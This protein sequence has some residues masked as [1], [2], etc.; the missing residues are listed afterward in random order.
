MLRLICHCKGD[1]EKRG[2]LELVQAVRAVH[3][4]TMREE[5]RLDEYHGFSQANIE[6]CAALGIKIGRYEAAANIVLKEQGP[7]VEKLK[8]EAAESQK[9]KLELM[10]QIGIKMAE[11]AIAAK[12]KMERG[13]KAEA[14]TAQVKGTEEIVELKSQAGLATDAKAEA[15]QKLEAALEEG[16]TRFKAALLL[17]CLNNKL[18]GEFKRQVNNDFLAGNDTVPKT[19]GNVIRRALRFQGKPAYK[20][21]SGTAPKADEANVAFG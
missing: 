1:G 9:L 2:M 21:L 19:D 8:A 14:A 5:N 20:Q 6:V 15:K 4:F 13:V 16:A 11:A 7:S 17:S 12:V 18:Y 10:L 3:L